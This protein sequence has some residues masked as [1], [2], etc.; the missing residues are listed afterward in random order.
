MPSFDYI[1][2]PDLRQKAIE[3]YNS[4]I[5]EE[6]KNF[7]T[8]LQSEIDKATSGLKAS[9]SK[10]LDEKKKLQERFQGITNPEEALQALKLISE[11]E[12]MQMLRDGKF[13]D[14]IQRRLST[15][16]TEFEEQT[17]EL[18]TKLEMHEISSTKYKTMYADL[19]IDNNI[20]RAA[21]KAGVLPAAM[22]DVLNKGRNL[23]SVAEDEKSVE[24][25]DHNG[26]LRKTEDEKVLTPENWIENLKK[27]S[28]HYWPASQ[29]AGFIPGGGGGS[30]DDLEVRIQAAA[31]AK[32]T[33]LFREL[34][35]Q[36]K[37]MRLTA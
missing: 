15:K 5:E 28:P 37:K 8:T 22:E 21:S 20:R 32:N 17:K 1:E 11:N 25:R 18:N 4:S 3:E 2:D 30:A 16:L 10:L 23:F 26:K 9:H 12:E 35:E 34:R 19:V 36:Q 29:S 13:E 14:V 27:T 24:S 33:K 31:T 6:K 7:N